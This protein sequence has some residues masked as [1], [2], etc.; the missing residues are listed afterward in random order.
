MEWTK[1]LFESL[2]NGAF[3]QFDR[4]W[5]DFF[6]SW[7]AFWKGFPNPVKMLDVALRFF[8]SF[9]GRIIAIPFGGVAE[10]VIARLRI[11][12]YHR[13]LIRLDDAIRMF[14]RGPEEF[15]QLMTMTDE[16]GLVEV[17]VVAVGRRVWRF[18]KD[19]KLA[20]QI[21]GI[22]DEIDLLNLLRSKLF[23]R[24]QFIGIVAVVALALMT[25]VTLSVY[26]T[27]SMLGVVF[28]QGFEEEYLLPQDS[29]RTWRKKGGMA[30]R[31]RQ[32]GPDQ[33]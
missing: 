20:L 10:T 29:K 17:L 23:R 19:W 3:D 18:I 4:I 28:F 5:G 11:Y 8:T 14:A 25:V 30:R 31:N 32:R 9:A 6:K 7:G 21:I 33:S 24:A 15:M 12:G 13:R 26:V 27:F 2:I 16:S 22:K 1:I